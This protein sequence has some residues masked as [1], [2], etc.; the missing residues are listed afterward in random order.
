MVTTGDT[1]ILISATAAVICPSAPLL[2]IAASMSSRSLPSARACCRDNTS[3]SRYSCCALVPRS[4][5]TA[6]I[7]SRALSRSGCKRA[8]ALLGRVS[9]SRSPVGA[10]LG[11]LRPSMLST[12]PAPAETG[13]TCTVPKQG[14]RYLARIEGS[15]SCLAVWPI[16]LSALGRLAW[17]LVNVAWW[18]NTL[19]SS[20]AGGKVDHSWAAVVV[21]PARVIGVGAMR[22]SAAWAMSGKS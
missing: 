16:S 18:K 20:T 21:L 7:S 4:L 11:K 6:W 17:L 1:F 14:A 15:I 19:R 10:T 9:K 3:W 22:G 12:S 13:S 8:S 2:L 5:S